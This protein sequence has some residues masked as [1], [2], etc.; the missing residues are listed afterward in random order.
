MGKSEYI[1]DGVIY[2]K[3]NGEHQL[4]VPKPLAKEVIALNHDNLRGSPRQEDFGNSMY[5][6][7]LAKNE[8]RR[9]KLCQGM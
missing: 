7:L 8:T 6:L 9:K 3:M 1:Y 2:R 4:V 5:T